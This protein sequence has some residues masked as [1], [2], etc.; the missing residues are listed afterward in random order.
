[1]S[2]TKQFWTIDAETDPFVHGRVPVPFMW[3]IFTGNE[4]FTFD[5]DNCTEQFI[6]FI[7]NKN[8]YLYAHNGGRF[9]FMFLLSYLQNTKIKIIRN[10]LVE[11]RIGKAILRDSWSI[12]PISLDTY[13]KTKIDYTKFEKSVRHKYIDEIREYMK[14]DCLNLYELVA[15]FRKNAGKGLTIAGNALSFSRKLN[16]DVGTTNWKHDQRFRPFYFGGRCQAFDA[17]HFTNIDI[18]DIKSAYPFAMMYEHPTG[19][20]HHIHT[21][22]RLLPT[23][24]LKKSFV[25]VECYSKGAFPLHDKHKLEFPH[26][27]GLFHVTGWELATALKHGLIDKQRQFI[28]HETMEFINTINFKPYIGHWFKQKEKDDKDLALRY[29]AKTM[30]TSLYGKLAQNP[31]EYRDYKVMPGGSKLIDGW[32]LG[33]EFN[34]KEYHYRPVLHNLIEK[35]GEKWIRAPIYYNVATAASITGFVRA[36]LL[37]AMAAVGPDRVLYCDTDSLFI[38]KGDYDGL[39]RDG[40]LGAWG[41]DGRA[42]DCYIGGRKMYVAYGDQFDKGTKKA[43]KGARLTNKEI[44]RVAMGGLVKWSN[45][46]PTFAIDGRPTFIVRSLRRTVDP[47]T[48]N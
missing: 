37:Q 20:E 48:H 27:Y 5:G 16:I 3:G 12:I 21:D 2:Q 13:K 18:F 44:E 34:D 30:L 43:S 25:K 40:K 45:P 8:V 41:W 23:A 11:I 9:D 19:K 31:V 38:N 4:Y 14:D 6:S 26:A 36:M 39:R 28:I 7:E 1:M 22:G 42:D 35:Y 47:K 32:K 29:I 24:R 10:R 46:A 15:S 33:P 17:G